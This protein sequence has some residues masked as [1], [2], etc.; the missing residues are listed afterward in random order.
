MSED[1]KRHSFRAGE[2][3]GSTQVQET[4]AWEEGC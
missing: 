1:W 2:G 4:G 3:I